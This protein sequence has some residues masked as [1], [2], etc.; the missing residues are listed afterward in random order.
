M[1]SSIYSYIGKGVIF[2]FAL[3]LLGLLFGGDFVLM[4]LSGI[5]LG[6]LVY[7]FKNF[8]FENDCWKKDD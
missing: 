3:Y 1:N 6:F 2:V 5:V 8:D 4:I 7:F